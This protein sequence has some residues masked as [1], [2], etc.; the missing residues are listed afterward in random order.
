MRRNSHVERTLHGHDFLCSIM[1][2]VLTTC[3]P[4]HLLLSYLRVA[5]LGLAASRAEDLL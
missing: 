5:E 3:K 4:G 2:A 1:K